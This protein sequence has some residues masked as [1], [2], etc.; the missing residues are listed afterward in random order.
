MR[1]PR[2]SAL[3][4][5]MAARNASSRIT[6]VEIPRPCLFCVLIGLV[7]LLQLQDDRVRVQPCARQQREIHEVTNVDHAFADALEVGEKPEARDRV[8][9]DLGEYRER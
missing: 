2:S 8:D 4:A 5:M 3:L 1:Q 6:S 9:E 7:R